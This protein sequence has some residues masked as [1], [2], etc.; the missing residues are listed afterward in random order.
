MMHQ[1]QRQYV[2]E[3]DKLRIRHL[4]NMTIISGGASYEQV[5]RSSRLAALAAE[6]RKRAIEARKFT[7]PPGMGTTL[8]S[9]SE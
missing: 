2:F 3:A 5:A 8:R 1:L 9:C 4:T 6:E 7:L